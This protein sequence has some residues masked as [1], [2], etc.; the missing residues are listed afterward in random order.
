MSEMKIVKR[1]LSDLR[2]PDLN[3]RKHPEKQI[4]EL[5]RSIQKNGQTRLLVIDEN[6]IIWIGNG[7]YQAMTELGMTEAY[8]LVKEGMSDTD[9]K[10]MMVSDN[11]IFDL[12]VDD[13]EALEKLLREI[14]DL[15]VPGYDEELL[16]TMMEELPDV[17]DLI[18]HS[19]Q[20]EIRAAKEAYEKKY[21]EITANAPDEPNQDE[22][23]P[24][25]DDFDIEAEL[26]RP[27]ITKP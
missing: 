3:S 19:Q 9:K 14:D 12:G 27:C 8:C 10:K 25:D 20:E 22:P 13:S 5:K 1:N 15:D 17:D 7:L 23:E 18:N 11:R 6:N 26:K 2:H 24:S 16:R 21:A 4:R